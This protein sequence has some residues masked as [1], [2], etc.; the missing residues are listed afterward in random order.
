MQVTTKVNPD[1][2]VKFSRVEYY[3]K[4]GVALMNRIEALSGQMM[5]DIAPDLEKRFWASYDDNSS[6]DLIRVYNDLTKFHDD[7][8]MD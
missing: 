8:T 4:Q 5:Q 3:K 7:I 6:F 1:T 2:N